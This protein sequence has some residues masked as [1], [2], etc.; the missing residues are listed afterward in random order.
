MIKKTNARKQDKMYCACPCFPYPAHGKKAGHRDFVHHP[1]LAPKRRLLKQ[2]LYES[3]K[4]IDRYAIY[5][6]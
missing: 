2:G 5:I 4:I 3:T 1:K 6:R